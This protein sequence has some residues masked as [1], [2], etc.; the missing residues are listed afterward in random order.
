MFSLFILLFKRREGEEEEA[1]HI[2]TRGGRGI[3]GRIYTVEVGEA[4]RDVFQ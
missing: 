1:K 2:H 4:V 3:K